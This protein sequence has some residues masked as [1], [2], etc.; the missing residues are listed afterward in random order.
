M[1]AG[2]HA[3]PHGR[4]RIAPMTPSRP[5]GLPVQGDARGVR[6]FLVSV[7]AFFAD[8]ALALTLREVVGRS[9][10][11]SAAIGFVAAWFGSYLG[12]EYWTFRGQGSRASAGRLARNLASNGAALATR[13]A[14]IFTLE[15][16]HTPAAAWL[17]AAYLIF[18]AGCSFTV[19]Y[20][21][22]RFWVF[23]GR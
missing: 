19:N 4:Y 9:V 15:S 1:Q 23:S 3:G 20:L 17:A 8:L 14:I 16:L 10:T 21:L 22:N 6:F 11:Q 13:L 2:A 18:G 5:P 7:A 12:H